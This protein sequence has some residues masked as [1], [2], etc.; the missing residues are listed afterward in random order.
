MSRLPNPGA[1]SGVWGDILNDFLLTEHNADGTLKMRADGTFEPAIT[2][3]ATTQYLRGDKTWQVLDKNSVGLDQVDNTSDADKPVGNATQAA[4][5]AKVSTAG[6]TMTGTLNMQSSVVMQSQ[7]R[8]RGYINVTD[9]VDLYPDVTNGSETGWLV[10]QVKLTG[11]RFDFDAMGGKAEIRVHGSPDLNFYDTDNG[12]YML[13]VKS[14]RSVS[15]FGNTTVGDDGSSQRWHKVYGRIG[16]TSP[17]PESMH[18]Q[19]VDT[20]DMAAG[21]GGGIG[22]VGKFTT[23]GATAGFASIRAAKANG[24]DGDLAG[25]LII[26]T[27][28]SGG[29]VTDRVWVDGDGNVGVGRQSPAAKLHVQGAVATAITAKSADYVL[30]AGDSTIAVSAASGNVQLTLPDAGAA[31]G[32]IYT[33]KRVDSSAHTVQIVTTASQTVDGSAGFSLSAQWQYV[34]VQSDGLNWL[35][36]A[37]N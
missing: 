17:D 32:R 13:Q 37:N 9:Y 23:G 7:N 24:T 12:W 33:L 21:V 1:D 30:T 26:A 31:T 18:Y 36:I 27:R 35:I 29:S 34:T 14:D 19:A 28:P 11:G 6:G 5:D 2:S 20:R 3:G 10:P 4:L 16:G 25:A 8:I 15:L 22:F